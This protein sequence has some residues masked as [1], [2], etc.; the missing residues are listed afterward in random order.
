MFDV[1]LSNAVTFTCLSVTCICVILCLCVFQASTLPQG[2]INLNQCVD[3][4]DGESRSGQ[5]YSLCI[6]TPERDHYIRA[7]NK[8][9]IHG[10]VTRTHTIVETGR[11]HMLISH[12]WWKLWSLHIIIVTVTDLSNR[13]VFFCLTHLNTHISLM[14][15]TWIS[16]S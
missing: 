16:Q 10:W 14:W 5:K 3:V 1:L 9:V 7:E 15:W 4:V 13:A 6:C 11:S 8:E 2:T 12:I